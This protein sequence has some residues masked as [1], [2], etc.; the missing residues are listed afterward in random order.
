MDSIVGYT[1]REAGDLHR[2]VADELLEVVVAGHEVGLAVDLDEHA[3][4]GRRRGCTRPPGPRGR[5]GRPS[6]RLPRRPARGAATT[7][8][9][10]SPPVSSRARLQSMN[11]APVRSRSSLTSSGLI[12]GVHHVVVDPFCRSCVSSGS[13]APRRRRRL[14]RP[15]ACRDSACGRHGGGRLVAFDASGRPAGALLVLVR[16]GREAVRAARGDARP[17]PRRWPPRP[18]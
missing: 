6:W 10:R 4:R 8:L 3:Q 9:S 12:V 18:R 16:L 13:A 14:R 5:R 17:S 1:R 7:A 11:P 15:A 2:E